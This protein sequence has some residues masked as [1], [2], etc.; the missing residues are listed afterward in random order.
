[1][2]HLAV[3]F[4]ILVDDMTK[5]MPELT[6]GS[7]LRLMAE[8]CPQ[9]R[10]RCV[11]VQRGLKDGMPMLKTLP[12]SALRTLESVVR[13]RGFG[14]A[15][16]ELRVTQSAVSQHIKQ[17]ED[18]LGHQ[19]LIRKGRETLPTP[20]GERLAAAVQT[21]F[22]AVER[23]CDDLRDTKITRRDDL[24]VAAP[25]GF[26]FV[27]LLPRLMRF[28]ALHR[29]IS[30]SLST[31]PKSQA[32]GS[33]DADLIISYSLGGFA[34]M[35]A[36]WLMSE[37]MAPVCA[38]QLAETLHKVEDLTEHVI[39]QDTLDTPEH[40]RNWTFWANEVNVTLPHFSRTR[41]Y[42]QAN[43]VIQA[44]IDGVGVAMGRSPLVFDAI[45]RGNLVQPFEQ[46]AESQFS[47]WIVCRHD[48]LK[49]K[50][51]QAFRSWLHD[52]AAQTQT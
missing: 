19:L 27:W 49:S 50:S 16:E 28:D 39:L 10:H 41:T 31:D 12:F 3:P 32:P 15:A 26:A 40:R 1:M 17:L 18:W 47:Y 44:A 25:P 52:A 7:G 22:G 4:P 21:G 42:G 33:S 2:L 34:N 13:L 38:P 20:D 14:R 29:D 6:M 48:A 8:H 46:F 23:M 11:M 43:M 36:E 5:P 35:H 24:L 51:V 30:I 37:Q 9:T 45:A